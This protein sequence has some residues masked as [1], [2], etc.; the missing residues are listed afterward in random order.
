VADASL[1]LA[2]LRPQLSAPSS[3]APPSSTPQA[4]SQTRPT[5]L[6]IVADMPGARI[7]LDGG[8]VGPSPLIREVSPGK[9]RAR[10]SAPGYV[11][12]ERDVTAVAGEL[13]LSEVRLPERPT[14]L[15]VWAPDGSDI[16]VDGVYVTRGGPLATIPLATGAHQLAVGKPGKV[17]VRRDFKLQRGQT[18]TE[19]VTL[20]D[21]T[22]RTLSQALFIGSGIAL[23]AG[24]VLSAFAIR[25]ENK[26]EDFLNGRDPDVHGLVRTDQEATTPADLAAYNAALSE[27]VR[28]RT[29]A[30]IGIASSVGMFITGLFL[31]EMDRP[32]VSTAPRRD[33]NRDTACLTPRLSFEPAVGTGD[34]GASLRLNF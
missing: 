22:Q 7:A 20:E 21:T 15:Y 23:G 30:A 10:I 18:H 8:V 24:V 34:P 6:M 17:L 19:Y 29:A 16:Y 25:S 27:R 14:F 3:P 28:F 1:A 31:Q 2:E 26:A 13:I 33:S 11:D 32:N 5:R 4:E 12:V 9:H